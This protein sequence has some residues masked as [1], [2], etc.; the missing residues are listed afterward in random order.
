MVFD[1]NITRRLNNIIHSVVLLLS[2][3]LILLISYDT[4]TGRIFPYNHFYMVFQFWVC[5]VFILSFFCQWYLA[6]RRAHYFF[7]YLPMLLVSIPYLNILMAFNVETDAEVFYYLRFLPLLRAAVAVA[8]VI[9]AIS[10]SRIVG[11]FASYMCIMALVVYSASLIF[12]QREQ[13]VNPDVTNYSNSLW[14][15]CLETTTLGAPINPM[16][17]TGKVLA[18]VLSV[19]GMIMFPLFTVYLTSLV[20]KYFKLSKQTDA[21]TNSKKNDTA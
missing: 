20:R 12:L 4:F 5:V 13:L 15:C 3:C 19:M 10:K 16:T 17:P 11:L 9:G 21:A 2:L 14:W 6:E 7:M 8:I 1:S 18:V